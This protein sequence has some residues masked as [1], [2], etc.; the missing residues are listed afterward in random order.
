MYATSQNAR[1][2]LCYE[3]GLADETKVIGFLRNQGYQVERSTHEEN[4]KQDIDCWV[5][6]KPTSIKSQHKGVSFRNIGFELANQLTTKADCAVT[7]NLLASGL[8]TLLDVGTLISTGS[9][10]SSWW[11]NGTA[12]NYLFYQGSTL[13]LYTKESLK[14]FIAANGFLRIRALTEDTASYLGGRYRHC[15]SICGYLCWDCVPHRIWKDL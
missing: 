10:E 1:L 12:T 5:N 14:R 15:N 9:W 7:S 13:R 2:A 4:V 3:K 8:T 6:G 11:D